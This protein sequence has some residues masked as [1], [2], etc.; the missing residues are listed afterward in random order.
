[1]TVISKLTEDSESKATRQNKKRKVEIYHSAQRLN[2]SY[3]GR[4][5]PNTVEYKKHFGA[6]E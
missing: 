2:F 1:M 3:T 5:D 6:M 4:L